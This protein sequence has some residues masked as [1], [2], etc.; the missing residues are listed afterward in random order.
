MK[1]A[2][3]V[4]AT[5]QEMK[6]MAETGLWLARLERL[7]QA[8]AGGVRQARGEIREA[9]GRINATLKAQAELHKVT[10]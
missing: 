1:D 7:L 2:V 10:P 9:R 5:L 8:G 4:R 6:E 3:S